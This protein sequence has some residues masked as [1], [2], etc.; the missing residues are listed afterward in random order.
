MT[1]DLKGAME[2]GGEVLK[3]VGR[4]DVAAGRI[5]FK[6]EIN[7]D[8]VSLI[9]ALMAAAWQ[10]YQNVDNDEWDAKHEELEPYGRVLRKVCEPH[11][12]LNNDDENY[13]EGYDGMNNDGE[14]YE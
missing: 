13:V 11:D 1:V 6:G 3:L 7:G 8:S 2:I 9:K 14:I 12:G 10:V 5:V 4:F